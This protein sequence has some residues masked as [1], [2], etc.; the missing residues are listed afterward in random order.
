MAEINYSLQ[1]LKQ[2]KFQ[3][4]SCGQQ[5]V[6]VRYVENNSNEYLGDDIGR[7]DREQNC[8]YHKKPKD[9]FNEH[10]D[11]INTPH[12]YSKAI[13]EREKPIEYFALDMVE[14]SVLAAKNNFIDFL[15]GL[16]GNHIANDLTGKYLIG[17]SKHQFTS[18]DVPGYISDKGATVFWQ[19]DING[20][21]RY[22]KVMLYDPQNGKRIKEPFN[23]ITA[24]HFL[25]GNRDMN[26]RQCFFG[27]HLLS[28]NPDAKIG[29]VESE[30]TAILASVFL[31]QFIWLATGGK[32]GVKMY[33]YNSVNQ[34]KGRKVVLFPDLGAFEQWSIKAEEIR[35]LVNCS[36]SVSD[37]LERIATPEQ[38]ESGLDI[39]DYLIKRD[40]L[41]GWALTEAGYPVLW[42]YKFNA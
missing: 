29:I 12:T 41:A 13:P 2:R 8:G 10:P 11:K 16:F 18:K 35:R 42:D 40:D 15:S 24:A 14:K 36:V 3:C 32:N 37:L 1:R 27:E 22:G 25:L 17:S 23:H 7:C 21:V 33:D 5:R 38:K 39:A 31:P 9:Y 30:K 26:Y 19:V 6:F 28:E 34:L 4:P 20:N